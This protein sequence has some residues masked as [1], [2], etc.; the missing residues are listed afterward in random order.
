MGSP[1]LVTAVG[2]RRR[3]ARP[4]TCD[5]GFTLI[6]ILMALIITVTLAAIAIPTYTA[7]LERAR[8]TR[9]IGDISSVGKDA[10]NYYVSRGCW[11]SSLADL[12]RSDLVD[13][14]GRPYVLAIVSKGGGASGGGGG[15]SGSG[16]RGRGGGNSGGNSGG[17]GNSGGGGASGSCDACGG[18]C[19]PSGQARQMAGQAINPD[20]DLYSTGRDGQTSPSLTA[21]PSR[22]DVVRGRS[23]SFVGLASSY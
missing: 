16:G 23:G 12:D 9:A 11:P 4:L 18:V 8:V 10:I 1:A 2:Y 5:R 17:S 14:W 3:G 22:D 21:A 13:P 19:V 7:A 20:F 6:E 15:N